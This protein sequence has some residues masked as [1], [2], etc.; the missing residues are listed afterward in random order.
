M[1]VTLILAP[2]AVLSSFILAMPVGQEIG[3]RDIIDFDPILQDREYSD[4]ALD[5]R[6]FLE[7]DDFL[8]RDLDDEVD[9]YA[10]EPYSMKCMARCAG[11][12]KEI[13]TKCLANCH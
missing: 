13:Q 4:I 7:F 5:A 6:E 10:R 11:L 2:L 12:R 1:K 9:I 3:A 8:E